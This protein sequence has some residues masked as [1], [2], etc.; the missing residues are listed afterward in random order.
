MNFL[1]L[2]KRETIEE[3]VPL[4]MVQCIEMKQKHICADSRNKLSCNQDS[5]IYPI[6]KKT[7]NDYI[8]AWMHTKTYH[9]VECELR[10]DTV[11]SSSLESHVY[12]TN[13]K[14]HHS[15]K[16]SDFKCPTRTGI[17]IWSEDIVHRC[18][19]EFVQTAYLTRK[20]NILL[21]IEEKK[22]Y[23]II[24]EKTICNHT[25]TYRTSQGFFIT[26][27]DAVVLLPQATVESKLINGFLV[28]EFD[29]HSNSLFMQMNKIVL[30]SNERLCQLFRA[31]ANLYTRLDNEYFLFNDFNGNEAVLYASKGK[32]FVP[33]CAYVSNLKIV[34]K[35]KF[36]YKDLP[37]EIRFDNK[38]SRAFL[39]QDKIVIKHSKQVAC[40]TVEQLIHLK[41]IK[42]VI[43]KKKD[44]N[45]N[46]E[47]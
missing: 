17:M 43:F 7:K 40:E 22:L 32:I 27:D 35:T 36:C 18:P 16:I 39:T 42:K 47:R 29:F 21:N 14:E 1:G 31:F 41:H 13:Q 33:D 19:Y 34:N 11:S 3:W 10:Q 23:Q 24:D 44:N 6:K 5:C 30:T 38:T 26:Q 28:S 25:R 9:E 2:I 20:N 46:T 15:C 37:V 12:V 45:K 4:D 8:A